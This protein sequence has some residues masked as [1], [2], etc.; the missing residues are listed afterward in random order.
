MF[1]W[2]IIIHTFSR[3]AST[4]VLSA[5][6]AMFIVLSCHGESI[7]F[8]LSPV[9]AS[10]S[11]SCNEHVLQP[12]EIQTPKNIFAGVILPENSITFAILFLV[13][14]AFFFPK[15]VDRY[16]EHV[17]CILAANQRKRWIWSRHL[18]FSSLRFSPYFA[19]QRDP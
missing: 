16:T 6:M 10:H 14:L 4:T 12:G 2:H 5:I 9:I 15:L 19:A 8:R 3:I 18:P 11:Q 1:S 7:Q 13:S 17:K